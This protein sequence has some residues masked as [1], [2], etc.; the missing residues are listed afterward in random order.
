M[1]LSLAGSVRLSVAISLG[2]PT[3]GVP[4]IP[5]ALMAAATVWA[6]AAIRLARREGPSR[7]YI[8]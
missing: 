4:I 6:A 3:I 7:Q 2:A 8:A 5:I 1:A